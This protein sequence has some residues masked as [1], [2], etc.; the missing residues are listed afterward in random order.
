MWA[1]EV[2]S[3]DDAEERGENGPYRPS[4]PW[5]FPRMGLQ[6]Y[7]PAPRAIT[8]QTFEAALP[9][10]SFDG[11]DRI[12]PDVDRAVEST[13][14]QARPSRAKA[15][16]RTPL[17]L[18][19]FGPIAREATSQNVTKPCRS[20]AARV[21]PSGLMA[22]AMTGPLAPRSAFALA[23][24]SPN[25]R[26]VPVGS[27]GRPVPE[28]GRR[29]RST[30]RRYVRAGLSIENRSAARPCPRFAQ[31][32]RRPKTPWSF[33]LAKKRVPRRNPRGP[34]SA[35]S[36]HAVRESQRVIRPSCWPTASIE[37]SG[38][39]ARQA[40]ATG[41]F[42]ASRPDRATC[43]P[44]DRAAPRAHSDSPV[45]RTRLS[46]LNA[47][48][49]TC[50]GPSGKNGCSMQPSS[51]PDHNRAVDSDGREDRRRPRETRPTAPCQCGRY[52]SPSRQ[53]RQVF[54]EL[55][56]SPIRHAAAATVAPRQ[57]T[58]GQVTSASRTECRRSGRPA[59]GSLCQFNPRQRSSAQDIAIP[60]PNR[61][62]RRSSRIKCKP[63]SAYRVVRPSHLG[64]F[65]G[66]INVFTFSHRRQGNL[67]FS[68]SLELNGT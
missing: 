5:R 49:R 40:A 23:T 21:D 19:R 55:L 47:A 44:R 2:R 64:L 66:S 22:T 39:K 15:R 24:H 33:H 62:W 52:A 48:E 60:S 36:L 53:S 41:G 16:V 61:A 8:S 46:V 10:A 4:L 18:R 31:C 32:G 34:S 68:A 43:G 6:T 20:A 13:G 56:Q 7:E 35:P 26:V 17:C 51:A 14:R 54:S 28:G 57:M 27:P 30:A 50:P 29:A 38:A 25:P 67:L 11:H 58:I 63:R 59:P 45:A 1:G 42:D 9:Q 37:P 12:V 3:C 65:R